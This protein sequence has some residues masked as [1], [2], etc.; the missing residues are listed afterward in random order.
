[1]YLTYATETPPWSSRLLIVEKA[2]RILSIEDSQQKPE[3]FLDIVDRVG[4]GGSEQGLLSAAFP[5]DFDTSRVFYVNYTDKA[6]ATAIARYRMLDGGAFQGDPASEKKLLE[7][8]QPAANHNGGQLQFGPDGYLYIG[9]GDGGRAD[10]PWGNAQNPA[11]LLG[12]MLRIDVVE[13]ESNGYR[14]PQNN[15]FF[16]QAKIRSEIWALG[17]RNPWR[18]SFDRATGDLYIADVGQNAFEEINFQPSFSTGG[19]N[20][21]WNILEGRHCPNQ[22]R[23][24]D[25]TGLIPPVVE[26]A[27][28]QGCSITGGYVYRGKRY[29]ELD[30]VY[31]YGDFCSGSIWGMRRASSGTWESALLL[32]TDIRI[33]SFGQDAAGEIYVLGFGDGTIY[34]L[35]A[36]SGLVP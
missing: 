7:I 5:H 25:S 21:G 28:D 4:S 10:D 14:I 1:V 16:D 17:L 35:A 24:C 15:P 29:P 20:Y 12:K 22:N 11:A 27:H 2:G 19:E 9:M 33:S 23:G 36:L 3:P 13:S 34:R 8:P 18:F 6:G 26:Y 32:D 31:I 30:G